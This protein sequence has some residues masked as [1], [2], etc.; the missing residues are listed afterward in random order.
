MVEHH[1]AIGGERVSRK[2]KAAVGCL[3]DVFDLLGGRSA[4]GVLPFNGR[5]CLGSGL[6][7][8]QSRYGIQENAHRYWGWLALSYYETG[9]N[10]LLGSEKQQGGSRPPCCYHLAVHIR[11]STTL[12]FMDSEDP[13]AYWKMAW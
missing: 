6:E 4:E 7:N 12:K 3:K 1:I 9:A 10:Y 2:N 13:S 5:G 8:G 11:H